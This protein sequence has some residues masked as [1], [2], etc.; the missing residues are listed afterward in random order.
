MKMLWHHLQRTCTAGPSQSVRLPSRFTPGRRLP[1]LPSSRGGAP[2]T[3]RRSNTRINQATRP[4]YFSATPKCLSITCPAPQFLCRLHRHS[5]HIVGQ[6]TPWRIWPAFPKC[7]RA[8]RP[9]NPNLVQHPSGDPA[10]QFPCAYKERFTLLH[11]HIA[12]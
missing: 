10:P 1:L 8:D 6:T 4:T 11:M 5:H 7:K 2:V 3:G 12:N 9:R